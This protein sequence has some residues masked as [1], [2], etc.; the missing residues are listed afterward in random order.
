MRVRHV[1][2]RTCIACR[3]A[4]PKRELLRVVRGTGGAVSVDRTGKQ[5]G[6]GAYLCAAGTCWATA[7]KRRLLDRA[8]KCD[9]PATD[10]VALAAFA[11][12]LETATGPS[13]ASTFEADREPVEVGEGS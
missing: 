11:E 4:R 13:T 10:R 1:P 9:V 2:E 5:A 8:L 6:R 12:S 7:I 3:S